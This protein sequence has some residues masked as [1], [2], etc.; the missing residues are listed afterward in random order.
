MSAVRDAVSDVESVST[1]STP[2]TDMST[3][4][5]PPTSVNEATD[6]YHSQVLGEDGVFV[7]Y[8]QLA[9]VTFRLDR[10]NSVPWSQQVSSPSVLLYLIVLLGHLLSL[11]MRPDRAH[12]NDLYSC[13]NSLSPFLFV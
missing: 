6:D 10:H 9:S 5:V 12:K 4:W 13:T 1:V 7:S 8:S 2:K 3:R 11:H